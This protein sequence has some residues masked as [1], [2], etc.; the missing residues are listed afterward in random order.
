[1]DKEI[2]LRGEGM[3]CIGNLVKDGFIRPIDIDGQRYGSLVDVISVFK[4][5]V[6]R[7]NQ[8]WSDNKDKIFTNDQGEIDSELYAACVWLKLPAEDG[9]MRNTEVAPLWVCVY[10]AMTINQDFRKRL[11]QFTTNEI[12]YRLGNVARGSEWAAD[13]IHKQLMD[14]G[15]TL[16]FKGDDPDLEYWQQ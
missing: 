2:E 6:K 13:S 9:K 5:T 7:A 14:G 4:P 15:A 12:K 1:M 16:I 10:V 11:A 8:Y 3:D